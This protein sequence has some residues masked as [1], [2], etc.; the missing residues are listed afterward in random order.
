VLSGSTALPEVATAALVAA[1]STM[2]F[3]WDAGQQRL[4]VKV[5]VTS[6]S[7]STQGSVTVRVRP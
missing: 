3:A 7:T 5:L 6:P 1:G 4:H 2:A